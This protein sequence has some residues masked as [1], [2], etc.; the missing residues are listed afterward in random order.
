MKKKVVTFAINFCPDKF[1][2]VIRITIKAM[3]QHTLFRFF[4]R[5]VYLFSNIQILRAS[6]DILITEY[7]YSEA[8]WGFDKDCQSLSGAYVGFFGA[9]TFQ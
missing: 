1:M 9:W 6:W 4:Y 5:F 3:K 8:G 7:N 2:L